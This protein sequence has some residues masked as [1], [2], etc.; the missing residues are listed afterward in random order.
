MPKELIVL[1]DGTGNSPEVNKNNP[2]NVQV[3]REILGHGLDPLEPS[4]Y[5]TEEGEVN[6]YN[7]PNNNKRVVY[8]SRGL[9]SDL[10]PIL[11]RHR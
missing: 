4:Q 10:H 1:C 5:S 8:Y 11:R 9:G 6:M 2:T 7:L 3:L